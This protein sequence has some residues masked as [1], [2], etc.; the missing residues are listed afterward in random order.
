MSLAAVLRQQ[1]SSSLHVC[2]A[3]SA[4]KMASSPLPNLLG[5]PRASSPCQVWTCWSGCEDSIC[6]KEDCIALQERI[7][8][9]L[10]SASN[11]ATT[12]TELDE[13]TQRDV[14][15][16]GILS[17]RGFL[18]VAG[19]ELQLTYKGASEQ[20]KQLSQCPLPAWQA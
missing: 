18:D 9:V 10:M 12:D 3:P 11:T 6:Q 4:H 15:F 13:A 14:R 8:K 5:S 17:E 2:D 1:A 7:R 19:N 20:G 16:S